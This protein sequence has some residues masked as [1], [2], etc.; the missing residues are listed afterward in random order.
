MILCRSFCSL[1]NLSYMLRLAGA[2]DYGPVVISIEIKVNVY[3]M[4]VVR[5]YCVTAIVCRMRGYL[6][7]SSSSLQA[8]E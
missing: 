1:T 7:T 5:T 4:Y 3:K 2:T 6:T 8:K